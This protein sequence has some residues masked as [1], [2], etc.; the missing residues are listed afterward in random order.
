MKYP[1]NVTG[2]AF[3]FE[4]MLEKLNR[5]IERLR[6]A[7]AEPDKTAIIDHALNA[8]IT[9]YHLLEW[10]AK[11]VSPP[12]TRRARDLLITEGSADLE[13]LHDIVTKTKHVTISNSAVDGTPI[14][15]RTSTFSEETIGS[16]GN[17]KISDIVHYKMGSSI[18]AKFDDQRALTILERVRD[19]FS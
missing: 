17:T 6:A 1:G 13:L 14:N 5:E 12:D 16:L 19:H 2:D 9:A 3:S 4:K 11:T 8:A 7:E 18:F 10:R 15:F